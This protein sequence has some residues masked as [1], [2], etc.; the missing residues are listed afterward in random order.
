MKLRRESRASKPHHRPLT[1]SVNPFRQQI[2]K[3]LVSVAL[4]PQTAKPSSDECQFLIDRASAITGRREAFLYKQQ[5]RR[6]LLSTRRLCVP[7]TGRLRVPLGRA[8]LGIRTGSTCRSGF[9]PADWHEREDDPGPTKKAYNFVR[10][11]SMADDGGLIARAVWQCSPRSAALRLRE[12][13][14]KYDSWH[15]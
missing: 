3:S 5:S 6:S 4:K 11:L 1:D 10:S 15:L 13:G 9:V 12:H 8:S 2:Y 14:I 7:L